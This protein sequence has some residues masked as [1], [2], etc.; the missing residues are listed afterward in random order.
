[1]FAGRAHLRRLFS[2]IDVAAV[3]ADPL[4]RSDTDKHFTLL[5]ILDQFAIPLLVMFLDRGDPFK[6]TGDFLISLFLR[7]F[8]RPDSLCRFAAA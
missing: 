2:D 4:L 8:A 3:H 7:L 1:M 5:D 6:L